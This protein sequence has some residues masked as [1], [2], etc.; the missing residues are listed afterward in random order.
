[1]RY[2]VE[3]GVGVEAGVEGKIARATKTDN[4]ELTVRGELEING[5]YLYYHCEFICR[6]YLFV[7]CE[8]Q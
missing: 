8:C 2:L 7:Y 3:W 1:M 6:V 4:Q 5:N